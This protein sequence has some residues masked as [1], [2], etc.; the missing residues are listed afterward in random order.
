MKNSKLVYYFIASS[1][2]ILVPVPGRLAYGIIVLVLFNMQMLFTSFIFHAVEHL[3]LQFLRN[4]IITFS[5]IA[6]TIFY[7]QILIIYCPIAAFT[8][9]FCIYLPA[10]TSVV[11]EFF[12]TE[13]Q[14]GVKKHSLFTMKK[15][16][17][18]SAFCIVYF[19]FRDIAG[20]GTVTLPAW[21]KIVVFHLPFNLETTDA[22][23]FLATIPGSLV[24]I[25]VILCVYIIFNKKMQMV[26]ENLSLL[27]GKNIEDTKSGKENN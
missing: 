3:K 26:H 2:A 19:L 14:K 17:S 21:K 24:L 1:L 18:I 27:D 10:L 6:I 22:S 9:G 15:S 4:S 7:R 25:S 11:I 20:F 8:L 23:I 16:L 12:F 5:L 13:Y